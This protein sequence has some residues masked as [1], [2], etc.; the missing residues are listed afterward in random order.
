MKINL[1]R[2]HIP[3]YTKI[4]LISLISFLQFIIAG[5]FTLT[6]SQDSKN[7]VIFSFSIQRLV[8][9]FVSFALAG[10]ILATGIIVYKRK[11]TFVTI[12]QLIQSNFV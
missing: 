6:I 9:V 3:S 8:L 11:I 10:V 12:S 4:F 7:A 1:K 2:L 5:I